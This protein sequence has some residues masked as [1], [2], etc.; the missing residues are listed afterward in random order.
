MREGYGLMKWAD[1]SKFEGECKDDQRRKGKMAMQDGTVYE[2]E[3]LN[4]KYH[5]VGVVKM[6]G[7]SKDNL[8]TFKG[9]FSEGRAPPQGKIYNQQ[10]GDVY[11]GAHLDFQKQGFGILMFSNG[12][13][14]QGQFNEDK[15]EGVGFM[16]CANGDYY[17]G[18][19]LN[20]KKEGVGRWFSKSD[21]DKV[22][23]GQWQKDEKHGE[24][25]LI[26]PHKQH[27][28]QGTWRHGKIE[29]RTVLFKMQDI[30]KVQVLAEK[31]IA[32]QPDILSLFKIPNEL[33]GL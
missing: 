20:D 33:S 14:Y 7:A 15:R 5:G 24:G 28:V 16:V 9:C 23:E 31:G 2:G 32:P 25:F 19:F 11:Y 1:G 27:I 10:S 26:D 6:R 17:Y 8:K 3:F 13:K 12:D 29:G 22:Y 21:G 4:D 18:E 30:G